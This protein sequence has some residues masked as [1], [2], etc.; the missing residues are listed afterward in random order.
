PQ[1]HTYLV[2]QQ[3]WLTDLQFTSSITLAQLAPGPNALFVAMLGWNVGANTS[4]SLAPWIAM[5]TALAA[6][7]LPSSIVTLVATR[8]TRKHQQHPW[9]RAFKA[10]MAPISMALLVAMGCLLLA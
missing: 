5:I 8:W 7:L 10:G 4:S 2:N 3:H 6:T 1:M 9:V